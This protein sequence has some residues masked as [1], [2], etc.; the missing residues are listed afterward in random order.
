MPGPAAFVGHAMEFFFFGMK[1]TSTNER[2][3]ERGL[4]V[5]EKIGG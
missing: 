3:D 2:F 1:K 5:P 4:A